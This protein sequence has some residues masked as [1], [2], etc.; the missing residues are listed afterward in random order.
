VTVF[1]YKYLEMPSSASKDEMVEQLNVWGELGWQVAL[2]H[3]G[4]GFYRIW[5]V[6]KDTD[7]PVDDPVVSAATVTGDDDG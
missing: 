7:K 1:K 3:F 2:S 5:L 4:G 6:R